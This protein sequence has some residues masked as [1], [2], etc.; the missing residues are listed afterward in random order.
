MVS[1]QRRSKSKSK[2]KMIMHGKSILVCCI[3]LA[4]ILLP[5]AAS[6]S[7]MASTPEVSVVPAVINTNV[8]NRFTIN[9]TVSPAG[10]EIYGAQYTLRFDPFILQV[11]K[12]TKGTFLS[13]DGASTVEVK[14]SFNNTRGTVEYGETRV[15]VKNGV[16]EPGTLTSISFE[17]VGTGTSDLELLDVIMSDPHAE[18]IKTVVNN[19]SCVAGGGETSTETPT[20]TP[21]PTP[22]VTATPTPTSASTH[23]PTASPAPTPTATATVETTATTTPSSTTP[24]ADI[25]QTHTP[26]SSPTE[27]PKTSIPGFETVLSICALLLVIVTKLKMRRE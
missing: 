9:V 14:N 16:E 23:T 11:V 20:P 1:K 21:T 2:S 27:T 12:Q 8:S 7:A 13:Q 4:F 26:T 5:A 24:P 3:L 18:S 22:T 25:M 10:N 17:V 6:T 19:G 15:G